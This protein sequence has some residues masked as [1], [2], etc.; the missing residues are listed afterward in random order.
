M[1]NVIPE[2][3]RFSDP[4]SLESQ[5]RE[6]ARVKA[7]MELLDTKAKELREKLFEV[8]NAEG[9]EDEKGNLQFELPTAIEGITRIEK[10]RRTVRKLNEA[11]AEEIIDGLGLGDTLYEMKQVIN[12]DALM[13][14]FY[15]DKITEE[16]LDEMFPTSVTWAL[17]TVKK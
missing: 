16:E 1:A 4:E 15:E 10:Q 12:E 7:T 9:Y 11:R 13:A 5:V 8:L 2:E 3:G 14:A 6:Y 17:R